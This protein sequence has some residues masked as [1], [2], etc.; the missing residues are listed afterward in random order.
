MPVDDTEGPPETVP[1]EWSQVHS[2]RT[3]FVLLQFVLEE[4]Q[5]GTQIDRSRV[6]ETDIGEEEV[7]EVVL[8]VPGIVPQR[9]EPLDRPFR[10]HRIVVNESELQILPHSGCGQVRRRDQSGAGVLVVTEK[11]GLPVQELPEVAA[12]LDVGPVQPV[13]DREQAPERAAHR[14]ARKVAFLAE[15]KQGAHKERRRE[16]PAEAR[17]RAAPISRRVVRSSVTESAK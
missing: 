1:L 9:V 13:L 14:K 4:F 7:V 10:D 5:Q 2:L 6:Q 16:L 8:V 17:A 12:D 11:V 15:G 3:R